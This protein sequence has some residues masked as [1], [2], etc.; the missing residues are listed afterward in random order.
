MLG[1]C[2]G[3][4]LAVLAGLSGPHGHGHGHGHHGGHG[5]G[6]WWGGGYPY[7]YVSPYLVTDDIDAWM[8]RPNLEEERRKCLEEKH[9][10][11]AR[12][13]RCLG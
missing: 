4:G 1:T 8:S 13:L 10:W 3:V 5:G 6:G 12:T 9:T 7:A 11:D 2:D